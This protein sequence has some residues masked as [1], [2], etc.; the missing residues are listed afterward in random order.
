MEYNLYHRKSAPYVMAP[1]I[2]MIALYASIISVW[3]VKMERRASNSGGLQ[4]Q[5]W[6]F[7][8]CPLHPVLGRLASRLLGFGW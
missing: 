1:Q 3:G 5:I 6:S 2:R 4:Y 7:A 8:Y